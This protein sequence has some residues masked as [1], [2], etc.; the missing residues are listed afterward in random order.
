MLEEPLKTQTTEA[1]QVI[2][3]TII[4]Y[5]TYITQKLNPKLEHYETL[6]TSQQT[7]RQKRSHRNRYPARSKHH[8]RHH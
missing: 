8:P 3:D 6:S 1:A 2:T 5:T 7:T 4:A